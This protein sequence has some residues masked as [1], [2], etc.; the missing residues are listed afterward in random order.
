MM[1]EYIDTYAL[2]KDTY[3]Y[4]IGMYF[5]IIF[6]LSNFGHCSLFNSEEV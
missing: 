3:I 1:H 5:Y 6:E 4:Y 2:E